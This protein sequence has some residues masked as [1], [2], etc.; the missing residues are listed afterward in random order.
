MYVC[1]YDLENKYIFVINV[2]KKNKNQLHE[3]TFIE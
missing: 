3:L 1:V 2:E